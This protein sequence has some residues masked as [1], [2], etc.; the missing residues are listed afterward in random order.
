M[1]KIALLF[2][3]IEG[4][5]RMLEKSPEAYARALAGHHVIVRRCLAERDGQ[6]IQDSGDGFFFAFS[7]AVSAA[8]AA[9]E[10]QAALGQAL[11]P[12]ETGPPRVRM[13]VHWADAV[14]REGQYR[15]P[16]VH[17]AARLLSAGHGGQILCSEEMADE[18][19]DELPICRLGVF[20]L[21]GF[22]K[23]EAIFQLETGEKF[24]ALRADQARRHN[25]PSSSDAF[26]GRVAEIGELTEALSPSSGNRLITLTG[27]GGI[28]KT[29]M[30]LAAAERLL[31]AYENSVIFVAL[32]DV[33]DARA[34]PAAILQAMD[35]RPDAGCEAMDQIARAV[36]GTP[37]LFV[38]DNMEQFSADGSLLMNSLRRVLP[39]ACFL[40]A[41]RVP[42]GVAG[43]KEIPVGP[44]S[45]AAEAFEIE[46]S[47]SARLFLDRAARARPEFTLTEA[48]AP[49]IGR[50]CRQLDGIPLAIELAASRMR[51][52][53]AQELDQQLEKGLAALSTS[54]ASGHHRSLESVFRWSLQMLPPDIASFFGSLS[55]FRGGWT[56]ATAEAVGGIGSTHLALAYLQ[57]LLTSSLIQASEGKRGMRF[58]MLEPIR[59]FADLHFAENLK[60]AAT[61]HAT[62]FLLQ[63]RRV[64]DEFGTDREAALADELEPET[65]NILCAIERESRN[66]ERLFSA[67]DFHEFALFRGCNRRVRKL[68]TD[69]RADGGDVK[70][71]TLARAWNAAGALDV[72]ARDL[73]GAEEAYAQAVQLFEMCDDRQGATAARCNLASIAM[74][75]GRHE[76]AYQV[77][78]SALEFFRDE[79]ASQF[80]AT[81]LGNLAFMDQRLGRLVEG[82]RHIAEY[83]ALC[84]KNGSRES[85]ARG[86]S[87][88]GGI[89]LAGNDYSGAQEALEEALSLEI[90]LS[91]P[92]LFAEILCTLAEVASASGNW[93]LAAYYSGAARKQAEKHHITLSETL[94]ARLDRLVED[95]TVELGE[96]AFLREC[97]KGAASFPS[98]WLE[99]AKT[100]DKRKDENFLQ[101]HQT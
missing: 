7:S 92:L 22:E 68:L 15:G 93:K 17:F 45:V 96:E 72:A 94:S 46:E 98:A 59:Q 71:E 39:L 51:V 48:N 14:F 21:R 52:L 23:S 38:L 83:L 10:M 41:S 70:P 60:E 26:I 56:A 36:V 54:A 74:E 55:V 18:L 37:I 89:Q 8:H 88:L 95:L 1:P 65:A 2:T 44:L 27:P 77:F 73:D 34:I 62:V 4:S 35:L 5:T 85:Y 58:T 63:A 91:R 81:I 6:E 20:R 50:I 86:L 16:A 25:L 53:T 97:R 9:R 87:I 49:H 29:R 101:S 30:A 33:T 90:E 47:D 80:C 43:E 12:E 11:W 69:A 42:L 67:V 3:D 19:N 32:A 28:G 82:R 31:E 13:A 66:Q 40:V 64:N 79:G 100:G 76:E 24:P 57:Y 84:R 75:R 78:L 61:L 99:A